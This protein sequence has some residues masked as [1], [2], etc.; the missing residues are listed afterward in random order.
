MTPAGVFPLIEQLVEQCAGRGV[1]DWIIAP[2]SRSAPLTIAL[3]RHPALR[4]RVIYDERSAAYV[5]MGMA[6][7][8]GRPVGLVCTSGTAAV[9]FAPAVTEAFYQQIPLLVCTADRPPEWIDQQDNQAIHQPELYA[10]H[11]RGSFQF[12]QADDHPDSSW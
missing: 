5:A 12:P 11:V 6:Q 7:Q 10:P 4:C 2:G 3:A 1:T 8:L 9:N